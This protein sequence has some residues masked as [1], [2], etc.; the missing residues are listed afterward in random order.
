MLYKPTKFEIEFVIEKIR[1]RYTTIFTKKKILRE[2]LIFYPEGTRASLFLR[3]STESRPKYGSYFRG[4]KKSVET[5][6]LPNRLLLSVFS[7]ST[8][9]ILK[10]VYRYFRDHINIHVKMDSSSNLNFSTTQIIKKSN[11][12]SYKVLVEK[13]LQA[14]DLSISDIRIKETQETIKNITF[15]DDMPEKIKQDFIESIA[16]QAYL[17]HYIYQDGKI[18]NE[19]EY[20]NLSDEESTG[21]IKMYDMASEIIGALRF[22]NIL[23]IDE[24]NSGLHPSLNK[25]LVT[26]FNNSSINKNNAQ[27]LISTHDTCILDIPDLRREQVW[28]TDKNSDSSTELFSLNKF[29]KNSI[30]EDAKFAKHYLEGRFGAVPS[31]NYSNLIEELFHA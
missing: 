27:L 7:N 8:N 25:F 14:A 15:P 23:I 18:T 30:R 24:F 21:T 22:G 31:I 13:F 12:T 3:E 9:E 11:S 28:F 17:G 1:Y 5:T 4:E 16:T 6:L 10:N 20:F 19:V 26:L 2:E 29:D